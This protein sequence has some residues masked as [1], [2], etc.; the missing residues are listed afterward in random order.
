[1][2]QRSSEVRVTSFLREAL[3]VDALGVPQLEGMARAAGL[4]RER[5]RIAQAKP[6][7]RA[8][9]SL[10]IRSIRYGFG[11]GGE[12]LWKLSPASALAAE[13]TASTGTSVAEDRYSITQDHRTEERPI[14][15]EWVEGVARLEQY[16]PPSDIPRYR[17]RQF[18]EDCCAF[19]ACEQLSNRAAEL[20]WSAAALFGCQRSH[21]LSY[22]GNAGLLWHV[23]GGKVIELHRTWA[24][25]DRP[26]NRAP[27]VFSR[28]DVG[29]ANIALPWVLGRPPLRTD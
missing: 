5:Q 16:Q 10:G 7:R 26:A 19:M 15:R 13:P 3:A 27:R 12:W 8:K 17:W 29:R 24:V 18:A 23:D 20:G 11:A 25:I 2:P 6:F 4:L 21:P 28:R 14:P 1:M 9:K 22:L